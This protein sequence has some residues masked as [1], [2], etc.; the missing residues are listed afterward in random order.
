MYGRQVLDVRGAIKKRREEA[1][2]QFMSLA[3]AVEKEALDASLQAMNSKELEEFKIQHQ[4]ELDEIRS[5]IKSCGF[6]FYDYDY[7]QGKEIYV[8]I[9]MYILKVRESEVIVKWRSFNR[10][11]RRN[12]YSNLAE[13]LEEEDLRYLPFPE[14]ASL[15]KA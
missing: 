4:R 15:V 6:L 13:R 5:N 10:A 12:G 2:R 8:A 3:D 7:I 11:L 14:F 1:A 9:A